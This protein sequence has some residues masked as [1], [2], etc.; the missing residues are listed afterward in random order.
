L[1]IGILEHQ[2]G[3]AE[4]LINR[5]LGCIESINE[6]LSNPLAMMEMGYQADTGAAKGGFTT[7]TCP[8][9]QHT[10]SRAKGEVKA[11]QCPRLRTLV[12]V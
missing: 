5:V 6:N 1:G 3:M 9:D 12:A 8:C 11:I 2:S 10:L 4:Q 7:A